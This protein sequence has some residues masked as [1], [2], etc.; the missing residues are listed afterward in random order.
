MTISLGTPVIPEYRATVKLIPIT[1]EPPMKVINKYKKFNWSLLFWSE[2]TWVM[3]LLVLYIIH[4][5]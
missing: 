2:V 3:F 1:E 5:V 4:H